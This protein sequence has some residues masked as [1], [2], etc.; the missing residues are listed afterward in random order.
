MP[1]AAFARYASAA[2]ASGYTPPT[3][4]SG[5]G[6]NA[7]IT[8]ARAEH[9]WLAAGSQTVQQQALRDF[10]QFWSTSAIVEPSS[11]S[12]IDRG[13]RYLTGWVRGP[14]A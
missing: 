6:E 13:H 10:A 7:V 5:R 8:Q 4:P 12:R 1:P 3:R 14:G 9:P 2:C 11:V